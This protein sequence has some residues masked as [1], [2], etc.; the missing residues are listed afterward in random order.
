MQLDYDDSGYRLLNAEQIIA[1]VAHNESY[2]KGEEDDNDE[3]ESTINV[4]SH[5]EVHTML[6][7]CLQWIE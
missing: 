7:E 4:S 1:A 5:V 2:N 6:L 3:I